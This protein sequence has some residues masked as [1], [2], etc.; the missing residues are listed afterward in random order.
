MRSVAIVEA[1]LIISEPIP[2]H[3]TSM[4]SRPSVPQHSHRMPA[5]NQTQSRSCP[6]HRPSKPCGSTVIR[7]VGI[8]GFPHDHPRHRLDAQPILCPRHHTRLWTHAGHDC[9][10]IAVTVRRQSNGDNDTSSKLLSSSAAW[11]SHPASCSTRSLVATASR[12]A[13]ASNTRICALHTTVRWT[14]AE[15]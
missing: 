13:C 4:S 6:R 8:P 14:T 1:A 5:D 7:R 12:A 2:N 9:W 11:T 3:K 10:S 15:D